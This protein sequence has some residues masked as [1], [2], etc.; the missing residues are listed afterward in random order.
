MAQVFVMTERTVI[1]AGWCGIV[2]DVIT[3]GRRNF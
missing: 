3:L 1:I 2:K